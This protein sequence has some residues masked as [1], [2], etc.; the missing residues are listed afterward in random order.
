MLDDGLIMKKK[1]VALFS[2][3]A[4]VAARGAD[5][6]TTSQFAPAL[7]DI[8]KPTVKVAGSGSSADTPILGKR[9]IKTA[10]FLELVGIMGWKQQK[11]VWWS[12]N[13]S[14]LSTGPIKLS[15]MDLPSD[16]PRDSSFVF[17]FKITS[18]EIT[19]AARHY[20]VSETRAAN[21]EIRINGPGG[22][23]LAN[24]F[25]LFCL[26]PKQPTNEVEVHVGLDSGSPKVLASWD[27]SRTMPV[28]YVGGGVVFHQPREEDGSLVISAACTDYAPLGETW[29]TLYDQNGKRH[30][31]V[32]KTGAQSAGFI[33]SES[34]FANL[35]RKDVK[36][37]EL[38]ARFYDWN[39]FD[40][41]SLQPGHRTSPE[42]RTLSSSHL[43]AGT[44]ARES[45]DI[46]GLMG[47][48]AESFQLEGIDG[49]TY[50]L[51][52]YRG[53]VILLHYFATWCAPCHADLP[54][55]LRLEQEYGDRG[56]VVLAI[57]WNDS[58]RKVAEYARKQ[59]LPFPILLDLAGKTL[60]R[61]PDESGSVGVPTNILLDR[62]M[63]IIHA[64][65]SLDDDDLRDVRHILGSF[66]RISSPSG[67]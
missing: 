8:A 27:A 31:C 5:L 21:G 24:M 40:H 44:P 51:S 20:M 23:R 55:V 14:P 35:H 32:A 45:S 15:Q 30:D 22:V 62:T 18:P 39:I 13:G 11:E 65:H 7:Q 46:S 50:R 17:L 26:F 48:T 12:A 9:L 6:S 4:L 66:P 33:S 19:G 59:G 34:R 25:G 43:L 58:R 47:R 3:L 1:L 16:S 10:N 36:S 29:L 28:D 63:R 49:K 41:V 64:D 67:E 38:R 53:K 37:V 61:F 57:A 54:R 56:L 52:D 60:A 2:F 42:M